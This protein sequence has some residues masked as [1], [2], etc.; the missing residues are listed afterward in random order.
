METHL[1]QPCPPARVAILGA[2]SAVFARQLMTDLLCTP[3]LESARL[4]WWTWTASGWTWR[5][6]SPPGWWRPQGATGRWRPA[7]S[8]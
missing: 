6:A 8:G 7:P 4:P 5:R 1:R 3:G 2:G